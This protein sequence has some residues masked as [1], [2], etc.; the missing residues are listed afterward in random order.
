MY[1]VRF[2]GSGTELYNANLPIPIPTETSTECAFGIAL[3]H[4]GGLVCVGND[5][6][7][8]EGPPDFEKEHFILKKTRWDCNVLQTYDISNDMAIGGTI[9]SP[10]VWNSDR[11]IKGII[12][13]PNGKVLHISGSGTVI[14]MADTRY[15]GVQTGFIVEQGGKLIID[16]G[17]T[18]TGI[19]DCNSMWDGIQVWGT[20]TGSQANSAQ[21]YLIM[22]GCTLSNSR[23]A[24]TLQKVGEGYHYNGGVVQADDVTFYN[25]RRSIEFMSYPSQ[26]ISYVKNCHFINDDPMID[27]NF[28]DDDGDRAGL[29]SCLTLW[30]MK[31]VNILGNQFTNSYYD[32]H[33]FSGNGIFSLNSAYNVE[34]FCST[35]IGCP[36]EVVNSF[37]GLEYGV[38]AQSTGS[39]GIIKINKNKFQNVK[40]SI[41][42]EG[43]TFAKVTRNIIEVKECAD[44]GQSP[45]GI[46]LNGSSRF[47]L[48]EN[49]IDLSTTLGCSGGFNYGIVTKNSQ[50]GGGEIYKNTHVKVDIADQIENKNQAL[51]IDCNSYDSHSKND[52]RLLSS[53]PVHGRLAG[54]RRLWAHPR[55]RTP[56]DQ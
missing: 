10:T 32:P 5:E 23:N 31:G 51:Q 14:Q 53:Y 6:I 33:V 44:G 4:D 56:A 49:E 9:A 25:N 28:V 24:V 42:L 55:P 22:E 41:Q 19:D 17:A 47:L 1:L 38:R 2:D 20:R 8:F 36:G 26:S 52:W 7:E 46:Y 13:I 15:V 11:M 18:I 50:Y 48:T 40:R 45:V 43:T 16:D 21:G 39:G 54:P 27:P 3:A 35:G 29:S 37:E 34:P 12:S 30:E